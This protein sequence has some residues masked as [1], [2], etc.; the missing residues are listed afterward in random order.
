[1]LGPVAIVQFAGGGDK[2]A[3]SAAFYEVG[4]TA[5]AWLRPRRWALALREFL[6]EA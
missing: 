4:L 1:M 2:I 5:R 6:E 3:S